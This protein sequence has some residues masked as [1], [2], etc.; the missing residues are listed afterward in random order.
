MCNEC[1]IK[2]L[3]TAFEAALKSFLLINFNHSRRFT[4]A[5][6]IQWNLK[7]AR[8]RQS[9]HNNPLC[10]L[11]TE[12]FPSIQTFLIIAAVYNTT[13][14]ASF[15]LVGHLIS[16][17]FDSFVYIQYRFN[18]SSKGGHWDW[19]VFERGGNSCVI[20]KENGL[21]KINSHCKMLWE[22]MCFKTKS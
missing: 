21:Y 13:L 8:Q 16:F 19:R 7:G 10:E 15:F 3:T 17:I 9:L 12:F 11:H 4:P 1:V 14:S 18:N 5:L 20:R 6:G 22:I 2:K